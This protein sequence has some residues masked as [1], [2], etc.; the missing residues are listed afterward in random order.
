[1]AREYVRPEISEAL[2]DELTEDR[3]L[4]IN[5]D[6]SDLVRALD[7]VQHRSRERQL[8]AAALLDSWRRLQSGV[9]DPVGIAAETHAPAHYQWPMRCTLFQAVTITP[10][11][12]GA[13]I[14]RAEIQPGEALSW[15]IPMT[16]DSHLKRRNAIITAFWMQLSDHDIHQLDRHTAAA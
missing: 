10:H 2:Y 11:L 16:A 12:T 3:H 5:P 1:M 6:P 7:T 4:L 15:P 14:E 8:E 9:L 13:L